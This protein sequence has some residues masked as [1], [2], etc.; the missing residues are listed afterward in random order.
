AADI[1]QWAGPL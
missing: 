1:S